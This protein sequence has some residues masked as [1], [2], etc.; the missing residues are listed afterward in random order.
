MTRILKPVNL[1]WSRGKEN[2]FCFILFFPSRKDAKMQGVFESPKLAG[3]GASINP[4]RVTKLVLFQ[5]CD[6]PNLPCLNRNLH[7][8]LV[9]GLFCS[10]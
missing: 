4:N 8:I 1:D 2:G 10:G 5:G 7:P 9:K 6:A 3:L